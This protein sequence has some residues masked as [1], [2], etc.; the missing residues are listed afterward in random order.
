MAEHENTP[1]TDATA[2]ALGRRDYI[3]ELPPSSYEVDLERSEFTTQRAVV[4]TTKWRLGH[5]AFY[6][7]IF[8]VLLDML[9]GNS[10]YR[11]LMWGLNDPVNRWPEFIGVMIGTLAAGA[12]LFPLIAGIRNWLVARGTRR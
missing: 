1:G 8:M 12:L 10:L 5:A 7:M 4:K 3:E 9:R 6:G 11:T 2:V